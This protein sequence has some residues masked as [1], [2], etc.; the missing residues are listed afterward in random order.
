MML[1]EFYSF[2]IKK[3]VFPEVPIIAL[4][5]EVMS[6]QG[7]NINNTAKIIEIAT[8]MKKAAKLKKKIRNQ[9]K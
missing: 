8:K 7:R 4:S 1:Y 2:Q 6:S 5:A 9:K 3:G